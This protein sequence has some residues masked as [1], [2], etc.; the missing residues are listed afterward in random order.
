MCKSIRRHSIALFFFFFDTI[1]LTNGESR[2]VSKWAQLLE[3]SNSL[4]ARPLP[5]SI[6]ASGKHHTNTSLL[7]REPCPVKWATM[8]SNSP[9]KS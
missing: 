3:T 1:I 8:L 2:E 6:M 5:G 7:Q 4:Q 9:W